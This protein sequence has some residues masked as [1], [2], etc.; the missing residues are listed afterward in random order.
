MW[1]FRSRRGPSAQ[2]FW[3]DANL[4]YGLNV[5]GFARYAKGRL[6]NSNSRWGSSVRWEAGTPP[7]FPSLQSGGNRVPSSPKWYAIFTALCS[8]WGPCPGDL[9]QAALPEPRNLTLKA[10]LS[11]C[12]G[13][14]LASC[15]ATG[16]GLHT[17]NPP[18]PVDTADKQQPE[19]RKIMWI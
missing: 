3:L 6:F 8:I 1:I 10:A 13:K 15:L 17:S 4:H 12:D 19:A 7:S 5:T 9:L 11:R 18:L 16:P 2:L 14:H